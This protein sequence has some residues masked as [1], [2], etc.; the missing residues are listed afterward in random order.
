MLVPRIK[1]TNSFSEKWILNDEEGM[2][3]MN[4]D[5]AMLGVKTFQYVV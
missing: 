5:E 1:K 4:P 3:D 2:L